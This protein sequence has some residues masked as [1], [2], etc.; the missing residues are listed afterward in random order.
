[1]LVVPLCFT[2]R[3]KII[4]GFLNPSLVCDLPCT[5]IFS[6]DV[7]SMTRRVYRFVVNEKKIVYAP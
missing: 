3:V 7:S 2:K 6:I 5:H 1:M 4:L